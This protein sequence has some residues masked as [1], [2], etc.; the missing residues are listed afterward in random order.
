VTG[1]ALAAAIAARLQAAGD[2]KRAAAQKR[3]MKSERAHLGVGAPKMDAILADLTADSGEDV[4]RAAAAVLSRDEASWDTMIAGGRVLSLRQVPASAAL[5]RQVGTA[6]KSVDGWALA[7]QLA[8][9]ARKCLI[10]DPRHLDALESWLDHRSVWHRRA[11]LVFTLPWAKRG[12]DPAR[13]L[14]WAAR[15]ANDPEWFVQKAVG[16]W[17]RELGKHDPARVHDFLTAH[18]ARLK[19]FARREAAKRLGAKLKR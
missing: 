7:D 10:A 5:W 19:P 13:S 3:Y 1:A 15:L 18:G 17:L 4:L 16:W 14:D 12:R 9:P 2:P 11:C 8:I 6:M